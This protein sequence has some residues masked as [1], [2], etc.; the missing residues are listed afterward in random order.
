MHRIKFTNIK[1]ENV[2]ALICDQVNKN[3]LPYMFRFQNCYTKWYDIKKKKL[4]INTNL[5][6]PYLQLKYLY[7]RDAM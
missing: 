5:L 3:N 4:N 2:W 6:F 1:T 7:P